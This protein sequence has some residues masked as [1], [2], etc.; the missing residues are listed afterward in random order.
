[1]AFSWV[2]DAGKPIAHTWCPTV[3]KHIK[4]REEKMPWQTRSRQTHAKGF[5][6][7]HN[8]ARPQLGVSTLDCV[9][10]GFTGQQALKQAQEW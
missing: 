2:D 9:K 5:L 10:W 4:A 7:R 1:M 6:A 3:K 8:A